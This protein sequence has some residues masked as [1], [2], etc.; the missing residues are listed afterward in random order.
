M[1]K[2]IFLFLL[3]AFCFLFG[4]NYKPK[5]D[6]V[7]QSTSLNNSIKGDY[8]I[9]ETEAGIAGRAENDPVPQRDLSVKPTLETQSF[10]N[11][12]STLINGEAQNDIYPFRDVEFVRIR[13]LNKASKDVG[14]EFTEVKAITDVSELQK[15]KNSLCQETWTY[16]SSSKSWGKFNPSRPNNRIVIIETKQ[17]ENYVIYLYS[18]S[19]SNNCFLSIANYDADMDFEKFVRLSENAKD[20]KRY[21]VTKNTYAV[22]MGFYN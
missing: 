16:Y 7:N 17:K 18:N 2:I 6:M 22:L 9:I 19:D 14:E 21:S 5:Y 1:R 3:F 8:G 15:I 20:F 12:L 13:V 11:K 10:Y 4:C